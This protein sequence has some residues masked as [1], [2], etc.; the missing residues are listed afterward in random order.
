M[1]YVLFKSVVKPKLLELILKTG[2]GIGLMYGTT[3]AAWMISFTGGFV[4]LP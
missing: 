4:L 3:D 1:S 2:G